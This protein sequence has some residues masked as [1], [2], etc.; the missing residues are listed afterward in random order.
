M[1]DKLVI[2]NDWK[3]EKSLKREYE[4]RGN[5][6]DHWKAFNTLNYR[7]PLVKSK[8]YGIKPATLKLILSPS[9][10]FALSASTKAL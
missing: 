7:I 9:K 1:K 10:K 3:V 8:A 5:F 6:L 4:N 2:Y